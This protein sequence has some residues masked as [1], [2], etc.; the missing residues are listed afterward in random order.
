MPTLM[1]VDDEETIRRG[2]ALAI[3]RLAPSWEIVAQLEDGFEAMK[4]LEKFQPD[5]MIVDIS[6]PGMNGLELIGIVAERYPNISQIVLSGHDNFAFAQSTLRNGVTDY[7]LKPLDRQE[8][9]AALSKIQQKLAM[10]QK[11]ENERSSSQRIKLERYVLQ[12]ISGEADYSELLETGFRDIGWLL[13]GKEFA[14]MVTL[15]SAEGR[16]PE[17]SQLEELQ[18]ELWERFGH[19]H[20]LF[21][22]YVG[23]FHHVLLIEGN[24]LPIKAIRD[25]WTSESSVGVSDNLVLFEHLPEGY[26]QAMQSAYAEQAN[27]AQGTGAR[28]DAEANL[29]EER[30][31]EAI[32]EENISLTKTMMQQWKEEFLHSPNDNAAWAQLRFYRFLSVLLRRVRSRNDSGLSLQV[33]RETPWLLAR[34]APPVSPQ[35][36]SRTFDEFMERINVQSVD[37][38]PDNRKVVRAAKAYIQERCGDPELNLEQVAQHVYMNPTYFSELFKQVSGEN[39][40]EYLTVTRMNAAK[41]L[42][43]ETHLKTYEIAEKVGYTSAKYFSTLFRKVCGLTPSEYRDQV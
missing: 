15:E 17:P 30:F 38:K 13:D 3:R 4:V 18:A 5:L 39:F 41:R 42:L 21:G 37:E 11:T 19:I 16:F 2:L 43:R 29:K 36:L 23:K 8:L 34:I 33:E 6:M 1:I 40:I 12:W 25:Y 35:L 9:M 26:R 10:R 14:V 28:S 27:M 7:L 31:L 32:A 20:Q 24:D 22:F